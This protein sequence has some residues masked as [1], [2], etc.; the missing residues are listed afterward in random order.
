MTRL[1]TRRQI[2][3]VG[4]GTLA[5]G[6]AARSSTPASVPARAPP[7]LAELEAGVGGR[8]GVFALDTGN[9]RWLA[10]RPNER[11]DRDCRRYVRRRRL[12]GRRTAILVHRAN[13]RPRRGLAQ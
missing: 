11:M 8:V 9:G 7:A 12:R 10:H 6:C 5:I 2:L 13:P 3:V 1:Y 4:G